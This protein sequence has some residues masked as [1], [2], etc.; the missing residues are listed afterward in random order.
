M[1]EPGV[2]KKIKNA[3]RVV[4]VWFS[5]AFL[6]SSGE[7]ILPSFFMSIYAGLIIATICFLLFNLFAYLY[8]FFL[9][10]IK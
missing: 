7:D 4:F 2:K 5:L 9:Q 3:S 10:L 6:F 8:Q 1:L